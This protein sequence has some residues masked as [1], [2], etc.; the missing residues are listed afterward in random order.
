MSPDLNAQIRAAAGL[1]IQQMIRQAGDNVFT[2][3]QIQKG[4]QVAGKQIFFATKAAGIFK[5]KELTDDAALSIKQVTPSRTGRAAPYDD[6]ELENGAV[7][8]RLQREGEK[9]PF[10]RHL[11]QAY[12]KN[13]PLIYLRGIADSLYEVFY[14][15]FVEEFSFPSGVARVVFDQPESSPM[16]TGV[17]EVPVQYSY[18]IRK[19]RLHQRA[20][21]QR[22]LMAYGLRCALTNL[23]LVDLLEAAHIVGDSE[24]GLASVQNGIAMSTFHHTA[25]E[26]DLMGIDP[27]GK[28]ILSELVR[29][30]RDGPM[31]SQGLLGMEGRQM[32][33]PTFEG[34]RPNRDFL[35]QKFEAFT[36]AGR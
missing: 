21:R 9:S 30:T 35:A 11:Q 10:N 33:F 14:P 29:G 15:V 24:G 25:Y 6:G 5:P 1:A 22:V 2:W 16:F 36:K 4:F 20:F 13:L 31:F 26:S 3:A 27:D 8:Y 17:N 32:R 28:I 34:H 23:P 12:L 18:G 19:N 7:S